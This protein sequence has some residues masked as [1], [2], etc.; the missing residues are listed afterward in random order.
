VE[1][2]SVDI[3]DRR[4]KNIVTNALSDLLEKEGD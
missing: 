2:T 3:S 1:L 4:I